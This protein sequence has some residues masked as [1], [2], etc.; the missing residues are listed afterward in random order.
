M[1]FN[2]IFSFKDQMLM[3]F[4]ACG[5]L[6]IFCFSAVRVQEN[7]FFIYNGT[8]SNQQAYLFRLE[9]N[10][11]STWQ[12]RPWYHLP[13]LCWAMA[14]TTCGTSQPTSTKSRRWRWGQIF[15]LWVFTFLSL[16]ESFFSVFR[17]QT[18]LKFFVLLTNSPNLPHKNTFRC[19]N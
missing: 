1:F 10:C 12:D 9:H 4:R 19:K 16:S 7:H 11:W 8:G 17:G 15:C 13:S 2:K 5:S 3:F 14:W 18:A 6:I